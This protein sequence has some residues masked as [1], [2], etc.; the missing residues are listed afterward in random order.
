MNNKLCHEYVQHLIAIA[1]FLVFT[2]N[3]IQLLS[4]INFCIITETLIIM[5]A[6]GGG[7][8]NKGPR[9]IVSH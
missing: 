2:S 9:K 6:K 4:Q 1:W 8:Q 7:H 5:R 3:C